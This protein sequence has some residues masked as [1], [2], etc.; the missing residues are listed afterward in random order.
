MICPTEGQASFG[1]PCTSAQY[2]AKNLAHHERTKH[3]K[4]DFHFIQEKV[5]NGRDEGGVYT[6]MTS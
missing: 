1:L 6:Y 4:V 2:I 3:I 5:T